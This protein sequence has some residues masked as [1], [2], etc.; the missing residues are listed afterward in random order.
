MKITIS[1]MQNS[2]N[3]INKW[4]DFAEGIE[5]IALET[6][7][8]ETKREERIFLNENS[9][10]E[11]KENFKWPNTHVIGVTEEEGWA[12]R[13]KYFKKQWPNFPD[14]IRLQTHRS[15]KLNEP[16]AH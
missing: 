9:T 2:L 11:M 3:R 13:Q 12:E 16:Q 4:L 5:D 8:N 10:S 7:Q 14:V 15:K 1:E 6:I